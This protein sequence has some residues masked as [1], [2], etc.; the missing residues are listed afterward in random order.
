MTTTT[1]EPSGRYH[2]VL[3]A[4]DGGVT[5]LCARERMEEAMGDADAEGPD[6]D[7]QVLALRP[8]RVVASREAGTAW[9][10]L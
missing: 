3:I 2:A 7:A 1:R 10:R 4:P 9:R 6:A 5:H 8:L